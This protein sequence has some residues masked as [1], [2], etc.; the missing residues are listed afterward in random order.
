MSFRLLFVPATRKIRG[1]PAPESCFDFH[2]DLLRLDNIQSSPP[3]PPP[4]PPLSPRNDPV[5][6]PVARLH[7]NKTYKRARPIN[8]ADLVV[9]NLMTSEL[10]TRANAQVCVYSLRLFYEINFRYSNFI[11]SRQESTTVVDFS[12]KLDERLID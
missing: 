3:T 1:E 9:S 8:H 11:T 4:P 2:S 6:I 5:P 12:E 7:C 10:L